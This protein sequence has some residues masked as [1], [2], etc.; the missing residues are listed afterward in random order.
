MPEDPGSLRINAQGRRGRES[1]GTEIQSEYD[2]GDKR[3]KRGLAVVLGTILVVVAVI[4]G[5]WVPWTGFDGYRVDAAYQREKTLWDWLGLLIVPTVL[6]IGGYLYS[7]AERETERKISAQ[8]EAEGRNRV[9][10][11]LRE[12]VLQSYYDR[13]SSLLLESG[14]AASP[15]NKQSS[16]I[17]RARTLSVLARL[18]GKR[19]GM[20]VRFLYEAQLVQE[21]SPVISLEESLLSEVDLSYA[22]LSGINLER[23]DVRRGNFHFANLSSG[24]LHLA[25][26]NDANFSW[27]NMTNADLHNS[28]IAPDRE[29]MDN[30][31]DGQLGSVD[32]SNANLTSANLDDAVLESAC[33]ISTKLCG[34]RLRRTDLSGADLTGADLRNAD[35]SGATLDKAV[36]IGAKVT[37]EQLKKARSIKDAKLPGGVTGR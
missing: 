13:I 6:A 24:R 7:R 37:E 10:E 5:Y 34:A 15:P 20:L 32:F 36:L 27:S 16:V 8:H 25:T 21:S 33:M 4:A 1:P 19:K 28:G 35:L 11:S 26:L 22:K 14:L 23:C 31:P 17:A 3:S 2:A 18:D 30:K 29:S 9:E 12:E